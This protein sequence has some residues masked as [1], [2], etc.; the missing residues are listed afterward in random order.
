[1]CPTERTR[2]RSV[3]VGGHGLAAVEGNE[4]EILPEPAVGEVSSCEG[5]A[6]ACPPSPAAKTAE[7]VT[8]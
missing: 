8:Q 3:Q 2:Q 7:R 5:D 4:V 1:M 6:A